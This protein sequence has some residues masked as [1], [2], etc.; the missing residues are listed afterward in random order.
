MFY[1]EEAF[2]DPYEDTI[3]SFTCQF[4]I[5]MSF[6][7]YWNLVFMV[8]IQLLVVVSCTSHI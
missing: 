6:N 1:T 7:C 2:E 8:W 5:N 4:W 3:I